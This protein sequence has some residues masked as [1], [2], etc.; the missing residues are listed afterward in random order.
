MSN[1]DKPLLE[2]PCRFP[3]KAMGK[4][5]PD[6]EMLVLDIVRAH[7]FNL[8]AAD[9]KRNQSAQSNYLSVT[10]EIEAQSQEQIDNIYRCLTAEPRILMAL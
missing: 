9:V 5:D 2:F 6:F 3:I 4:A 7:V 8:S 1:P 10:I